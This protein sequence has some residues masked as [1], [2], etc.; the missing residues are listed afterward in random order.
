M[1][2][3]NTCIINKE[4]VRSIDCTAAVL[5]AELCIRERGC[6]EWTLLDSQSIMKELNLTRHLYRTRLKALRNKG[7]IDWA[8]KGLPAKCYFRINN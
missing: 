4:I 6:E 1:N 5:Y 3:K 8:R 7:Y 2:S